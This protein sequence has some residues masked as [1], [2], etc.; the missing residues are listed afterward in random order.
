MHLDAVDFI[1][2]YTALQQQLGTIGE[3]S[4]E[5]KGAVDL[6]V[7]AESGVSYQRSAVSYQK[8]LRDGQLLIIRDGKAINMLG[9]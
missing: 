2:V 7:K 4:T 9:Y 3:T 1:K 8:V 5:I 6:H